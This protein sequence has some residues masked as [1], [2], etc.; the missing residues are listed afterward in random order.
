MIKVEV[1]NGGSL[2]L[3]QNKEKLIVL[4]TINSNGEIERADGI[5]QGDF[6]MLLNYYRY[7]KDDNIKCDFINPHGINEA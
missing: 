2:E 7:I 6:V 5:T 4:K 1:N 3:E